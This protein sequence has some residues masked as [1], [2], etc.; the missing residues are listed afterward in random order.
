MLYTKVDVHRGETGAHPADSTLPFVRQGRCPS[1]GEAG[2]RQFMWAHLNPGPAAVLNEG[3]DLG[4]RLPEDLDLPI[5]CSF[6]EPGADAQY[7]G[8]LHTNEPR[9]YSNSML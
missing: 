8:R 7:W 4:P 2:G 3:F 1:G 6:S 5:R 9:L